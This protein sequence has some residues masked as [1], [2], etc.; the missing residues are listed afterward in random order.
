VNNSPAG[1]KKTRNAGK[2]YHK[3]S[4]SASVVYAMRSRQRISPGSSVQSAPS[5]LS[6]S[7]PFTYTGGYV[8]P[9]D[10]PGAGQTPLPPD[11]DHLSVPNRKSKIEN[12]KSQALRR[13]SLAKIQ[14]LVDLRMTP[15]TSTIPCFWAIIHLGRMF[16][17]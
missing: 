12:R 7:A 17:L 6:P 1:E 5:V 15:A 2:Q 3:I 9:G 4:H 16:S 8:L 11:L 14:T 10:T 13:R